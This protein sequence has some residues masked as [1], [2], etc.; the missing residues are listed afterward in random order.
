MTELPFQHE[1]NGRQYKVQVIDRLPA[2]ARPMTDNDMID[3]N[4]VIYEVE[5]GT[6]KGKYFWDIITPSSHT[7][8]YYKI[9]RGKAFVL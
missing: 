2:A 4:K 5:V 6:Y 3:G 9:S 1:Y 8:L 7:S